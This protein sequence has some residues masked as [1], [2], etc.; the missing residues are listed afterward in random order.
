MTR[1]A[2]IT[3]LGLLTVSPLACQR[4]SPASLT[5][6][7]RTAIAAAARTVVDSAFAAI[8]RVDAPALMRHFAGG[9]D[10]TFSADGLIVPGH[11]SIASFFGAALSG[12]RSVDSASLANVRVAVLGPDAAVVTANYRERVTD[13]SGAQFWNAGA[14]TSTLALRAG[15]WKIVDSHASHPRTVP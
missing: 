4:T 8:V 7:E 9:P 11:D 14:W 2:R 15:E 10:A 5:E 3:V 13:T 6:A 12:W 1:I